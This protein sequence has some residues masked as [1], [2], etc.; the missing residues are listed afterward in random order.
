MKNI[1]HFII[2]LIVGLVSVN[3]AFADKTRTTTNS[4][5]TKTTK[6]ITAGCVP[7]SSSTSLELNNIRALIHTGGDMWWDLQ[8][9]PRYEV[10]KGSGKHSLFAGAIVFEAFV[11]FFLPG[12]LSTQ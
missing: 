11:S 5:G 1:K 2:L 4:D 10:P 7:G 9:N 3:N 12:I 8:G 6:S